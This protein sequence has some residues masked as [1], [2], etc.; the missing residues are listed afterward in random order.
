MSAA[1]MLPDGLAVR[2]DYKEPFVVRIGRGRRGFTLTEILMAVGILG[3]GLTMVASLFPVA[4]DQARRSQETTLAAL[5]ARSAA[6]TLRARRDIITPVLRATFTGTNPST[7]VKGNS[8]NTREIAKDNGGRAW[9]SNQYKIY[10]PD[11]FLYD[12]SPPRTYV[13]TTPTDSD[14]SQD[15]TWQTGNFVPVILATPTS[16]T[17][18]DGPWR[19]T[20]VV[21]K[22]HG[23]IPDCVNTAALTGT[24]TTNK[25][26][27]NWTVNRGGPGTYLIDWRP[28]D[29][30]NLRGEAYLVDNVSAGASAATD[31]VYLAAPVTTGT[32][33]STATGTVSATGTGLPRWVSMPGAVMVF[34]TFIGE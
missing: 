24:V 25:S 20:I 28:T 6:A 22:S 23:L 3:I 17:G 33:V 9:M 29:S 12:N 10:N 4:V 13:S 19:V 5:C 11:N 32:A 1:I 21:F 2:T 7:D 27:Q 15:I 18:Y 14:L 26:L 16:S 30:T 34:H 31:T 8:M